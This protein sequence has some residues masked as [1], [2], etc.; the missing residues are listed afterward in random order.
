MIKSPNQLKAKVRNIS[1]SNNDIAKAYIRIFFMERFLER[2]A[3]SDYKD[4]FILKGGML[5]ASLLGIDMRSTMDIDT[6]VRA[7]P[8]TVDDI[9]RIVN[10]ICSIDIK[11]NVTFE[12]SSINSIMDEFEYP[13]IRIQLN[14]YLGKIK[15]PFKIDISTDDVITPRNIEYEYQL[16]FENRT[17]KL[18][19]YNVE[20]LLAEKLQTVLAR[21]VA[22]TRMR[23]Y[24]DIYSI[25]KQI[26]YSE[27]TLRKAFEATCK[28]RGTEFDEDRIHILINLIRES[29][30]LS[31]E[32]EYFVKKNYYANTE[33]WKDIV[34]YVCYFIEKLLV[35]A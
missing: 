34:D 2:V 20:T 9:T 14:G 3:Y 24:F 17:I 28:K 21:N 35:N 7:L 15:Q 22:N 27:D 6:T 23:D 31:S 26:G 25:S 5:A 13:G 10:D 30:D 16:M 12:V 32:W 4:Q 1:G 33:T 19:S 29:E 18:C 11:D 8:L